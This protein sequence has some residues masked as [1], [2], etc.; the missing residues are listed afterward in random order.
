MSPLM[1]AKILRVLQNQT[2]ERVGGSETIR[3]NP[4]VVAATNR[5][6]E[7]AIEDKQFRSDLFYRLNVYTIRLPP[8]RER[9]DDIS[10][11][12]KYFLRKSAHEL[13]K[14]A[15]GFAPEVID[16]FMSYAWP[17][18]VR[19]LQSIIKHALLEST[20]PVITPAY[21]PDSIR[22]SPTPSSL[23]ASRAS[24]EDLATHAALL[25]FNQMS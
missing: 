18:N 14:P 23:S 16:R 2:F 11:L 13:G 1:Q 9:G 25:D 5:N 10:L 21:L 8:L 24:Q 17:G 4:R 3:T 6:L 12:A 22:H 7:Q 15:S 19:E 20:G